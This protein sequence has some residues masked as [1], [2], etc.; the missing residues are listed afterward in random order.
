MKKTILFIGVSVFVMAFVITSCTKNE[1]TMNETAD[2]V[3]SNQF[4][5]DL[6]YFLTLIDENNHLIVKNDN[7][8]FQ[9]IIVAQEFSSNMRAIVCQGS[10]VSFARC[11]Q[12]WLDDHPGRCLK[13]FEQGGTYFADDDC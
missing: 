11:V 6:T 13:I 3:N 12:Q 1:S 7:G 8:E 5:K 2:Q 10:G 4:E 9:T